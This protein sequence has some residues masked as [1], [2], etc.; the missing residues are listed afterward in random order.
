MEHTILLFLSFL[1]EA[2]IMWLYT[3][4][5]FIPTHSSRI[6]LILLCVLCNPISFFIIQTNMAQYSCIFYHKCNFSLHA[7]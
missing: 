5:L 1:I 6:R 2:V 4:N 3:S 7:I